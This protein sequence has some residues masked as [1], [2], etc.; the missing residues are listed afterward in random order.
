MVLAPCFE[1]RLHTSCSCSCTNLAVLEH[2]QSPCASWGAQLRHSPRPPAASQ[3]ASQHGLTA[4]QEGALTAS[5]WYALAALLL[6]NPAAA[7]I[8]CRRL[9]LCS[10]SLVLMLKLQ[11]RAAVKRF[12]CQAC[13]VAAVV[14]LGPG[15]HGCHCSLWHPCLKGTRCLAKAACILVA[16]PWPYLCGVRSLTKRL[17]SSPCSPPWLHFVRDLM[18]KPCTHTARPWAAGRTRFLN[19]ASPR[20]FASIPCTVRA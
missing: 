20:P 17:S 7:G 8:S 19:C 16:G 15:C 1:E 12:A 3:W 5:S 14:M 6:H 4:C 10:R 2:L 11:P 9:L 13:R 18:S